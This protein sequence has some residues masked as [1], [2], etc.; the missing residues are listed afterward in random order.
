[1]SFSQQQA[2]R[3]ESSLGQADNENLDLITR[4]IIQAQEAAEG[5]LAQLQI[6]MPLR[7]Q[8]LRFDSPL[9]VEPAAEMS[10]SF[11]AQRHTIG[12]LDPSVGYGLGLFVG[13]LI[14]SAALGLARSRWDRLHEILRPVASPAQP[15]EATESSDSDESNGPVSSEELI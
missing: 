15:I 7:G 12:R 11:S 8:V 9:Q 4:R 3:I 2:E 5:S 1:M 10:V 14:V 13:L 6:T